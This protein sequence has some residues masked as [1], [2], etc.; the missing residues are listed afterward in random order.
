MAAHQAPPFLAFS[1]QEHWSG[2]PFPSPLHESEKWKWSHSVVSDSW[3]WYFPSQIHC[4][5]NWFLVIGF[6][7]IWPQSLQ[8]FASILMQL[9]QMV[10]E[11]Q[12][13]PSPSRVWVLKSLRRSHFQAKNTKKK[14][15][16]VSDL[17]FRGWDGYASL[18]WTAC[19]VDT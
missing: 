3:D 13:A 9:T 17:C 12:S 16:Y 2:L 7:M 10:R 6:R 4:R 19:L 5:G 11:R 8:P 18:S 15:K 1:R 14:K